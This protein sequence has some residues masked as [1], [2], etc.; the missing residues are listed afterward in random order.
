VTIGPPAAIGAE[1]ADAV[2]KL[3]GTPRLLVASDFDGVLA[4]IV[5]NPADSRPLPASQDALVCLAG[6]AA[7]EVAVISGRSLRDLRTLSS[8][9]EN[10]LLVGSHGSEFSEGS[11]AGLDE[12]T[13]GLLRNVIDEVREITAGR[14]GVI[15]ETKPVSVAI[16][17]RNSSRE[18]AA[19]VLAAVAD[20]PA[21]RIGVRAL[22]GKEV[23]EL[24]VIDTSKG[25]ALDALRDQTGA[26]G[27]FYAG[28]DVTDEAAFSHLRSD[29]VGVK[30]GPGDSLARFRVQ[31]PTE[32][33]ALLSLIADVRR[34]DVR[35]V[36]S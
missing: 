6:L 11:A 15:V 19:A 1:L 22:P 24:A 14:P 26:T 32:V 10:F 36:G 18:T 25:T 5:N 2:R 30:V 33:S 27:V 34:S 28:D 17:V 29:D 35:S 21:R 9:P 20:G 12:H 3:A 31:D 8:A 13:S 23:I 16:H 7:T 4:P